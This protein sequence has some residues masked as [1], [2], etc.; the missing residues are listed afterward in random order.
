MFA[1]TI[2]YMY[3]DGWSGGRVSN[4]CIELR[5]CSCKQLQ[6][7]EATIARSMLY[8]RS[9]GFP[10]IDDFSFL[11][12]AILDQ[13]QFPSVLATIQKPSRPLTLY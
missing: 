7:V 12:R 4:I 2:I 5:H 13:E 6:V 10:S 8:G 11:I 3:G 9:G 1:I